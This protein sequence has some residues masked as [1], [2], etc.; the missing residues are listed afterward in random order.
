ML[1]VT[2]ASKLASTQ[3]PN[4]PTSLKL[5]SSQVVLSFWHNTEDAKVAGED[6]VHVPAEDTEIFVVGLE[7]TVEYKT[8]YG[9]FL[10]LFRGSS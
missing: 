8:E 4:L 6:L 3:V 1:C 5:D 9:H 10:R 2:M 7:L